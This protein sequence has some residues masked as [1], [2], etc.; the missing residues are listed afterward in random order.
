MFTHSRYAPAAL[1][2][3]DD[4]VVHQERVVEEL[5]RDRERQDVGIATAEGGPAVTFDGIDGCRF[6]R[7]IVPGDQ[8]TLESTWRALEGGKGRFEVRALIGDQVAAE[9]ALLV[10]VFA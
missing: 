8:L 1:A 6:K 9:S 4:V 2:A 10:T 3:V 7:Q 5:D